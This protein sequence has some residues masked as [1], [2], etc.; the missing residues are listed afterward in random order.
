MTATAHHGEI[1]ADDTALLYRGHDI[2][3]FA[4][5]TLD[6]LLVLNVAQ[7][8]NLVA[9]DCCL[10]KSKLCCRVIHRARQPPDHLLLTTLQKH[11]RHL[12]ILCIRLRGDQINARRGA[13]FDLV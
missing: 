1:D 4:P 3:V 10:L 5:V 9:V 8:L 6:I 13:P 11:R 12:N 2:H 7:G